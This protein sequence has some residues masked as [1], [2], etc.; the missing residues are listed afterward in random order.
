MGD[1]ADMFSKSIVLNVENL[2]EYVLRERV[3]P[4]VYIQMITRRYYLAEARFLLQ[5]NQWV[6]QRQRNRR[7]NY[8]LTVRLSRLFC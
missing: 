2:T 7:V 1:A 3:S 4:T 5:F 8:I 6:G